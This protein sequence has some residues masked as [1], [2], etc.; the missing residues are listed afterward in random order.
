MRPMPRQ[1]D[2][3]AR[4]WR[5]V[6]AR[7]ARLRFEPH[8]IAA[9][10]DARGRYE[11]PLDEEFPFAVHLF[12]YSSRVHTRGSTW[13]ERLELFVPLDGRTVF[14]MGDQQVDLR[15]GDLLVVDNLKLHHVVDFEGF[16][17]RAIVLSFRPEFVYSLGSP[18]HD[19]AFLLPFYASPERRPRILSLPAHPA[20]ATALGRLLQCAFDEADGP[21]RRAGCRAFLLELLLD[22][23]R[24]VRTP[25]VVQWEFLRQQQ[26]SLRLKP[27]FDHVSE[28]YAER[29]TLAQAAALVG[30]SQPQF[31]KTFKKVAGTTLVSY[32]NHVRLAHGSRLLL[33]TSLTVAEIASSVGFADQSYFDKRFKRAF[34]QTP[35]EFRTGGA[36]SK[37]S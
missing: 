24:H 7:A 8:D 27:L 11:V 2:V 37:S 17:T 26:R 9:R 5:E 10:L 3:S 19:Y 28:H 6:L 22:L 12:H 30:M 23:A 20:A 33:E 4:A 15:S 29:L 34:G 14:R 25:E 36:R 18:S 1:P 32:L 31:M 35:K 21:L 13:H 16:D